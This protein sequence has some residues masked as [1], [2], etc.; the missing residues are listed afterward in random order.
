MKKNKDKPF[1][2]FIRN[3]VGVSQGKFAEM[4]GVSPSTLTSWI[5]GRTRPNAH[6]LS[7]IARKFGMTNYEVDEMFDY[8]EEDGSNE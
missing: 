4:L 8:D 2:K 3:K 5:V 7:M 1:V 6:Y